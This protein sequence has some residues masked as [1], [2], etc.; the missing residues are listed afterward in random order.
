MSNNILILGS[1][2]GSKLPDIE[3]DK[4]YSANAAA[5]RAIYYKKK[6]PKINLTCITGAK[7]F[8]QDIDIQKR[9][10]GSNP[11]RIVSRLGDISLSGNIKEK[12]DLVCLSQNEQLKFQKSFFKPSFLTITFAELNYKKKFFSKIFHILKC[13]KNN[14][15]QG[16]STG[17][18]SILLAVKE[19]PN[20]KIIVTGTGMS[21][22]KHLYKSSRDENLNYDSRSAVDRY[23]VKRLDIKLRNEIF[24]LDDD[25]IKIFNCKKWSG[26]I[27]EN[28]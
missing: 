7:G 23:L 27:V 15:L 12:C 5:E 3:L 25:F 2:P 21:G 22:G 8:L 13:L 1:K 17:F 11:E 10:V 9:I 26:L 19:N 28:N 24:S 4:I 6:N 16:I 14:R 18:F 20:S